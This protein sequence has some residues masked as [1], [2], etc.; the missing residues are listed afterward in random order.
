M[1]GCMYRE[2]AVHGA[3]P[4]V[5]FETATVVCSKSVPRASQGPT[6]V[7]F[8]LALLE[9]V[10]GGKKW[11]RENNGLVGVDWFIVSS[12]IRNAFSHWLAREQAAIAML[13]LCALWPGP[14]P[15]SSSI[16]RTMRQY[17]L[18]L[19]QLT[20]KHVQECKRRGA[21][22]DS[23]ITIKVSELHQDSVVLPKHPSPC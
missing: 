20:T 19:G 4:V 14:F 2:S 12:S 9:S 5:D 1:P 17:F 15:H 11:V 6:K 21:A 22:S 18:A 10:S 23:S 16:E 13:K 8:A 3:S 7:Q